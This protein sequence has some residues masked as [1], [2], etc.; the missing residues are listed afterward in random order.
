VTR[1][2]PS[3]TVTFLFTDIEGSTRLLDALGADAYADALAQHRRV[4]RLACSAQGGVQVDTQGDAFFFAF[5]SAPGALSAARAIATGLAHGP[6]RVRMGLHTGNPL[7]TEEGYVGSDVHLAA[8]IAASAHGG[9]IVVSSRTAALVGSTDAERQAIGL[10]DLGEHRLKDLPGAVVIFQL[11]GGVFPPLRTISNTNLPR[12]ASSFVGRDRELTGVLSLIRQGARLVSLTG[13]GGSGKTRLA[14]EAAATLVPEFKAGVFWIGLAAL[15][16]PSLVVET[17][18]RTL[19]AK[20]RLAEH[21]GER[22]LLLLL[23]NLEQVIPAAP[24]L[25]ALLTACPNLT[26]LVTSRE[27]L[28]VRGEVE[29]AVPPLAL[30]EAVSLFCERAQVDPSEEITEICR[31][32]DSLP[33][34]VELA[35]A[36]AKAISPAQILER[37]VD[38]LDMLKGG[39]DAD[40]RQQTLRATI[41]WSFGLLSEDERELFRRLSVFAGG[42]TLTEAEQVADADLD[43]MQALVEKSLVR[44]SRERYWMLETIREFAAERLAESSGSRLTKDRHAAW[45]AQFVERAEPELEASVQDSWLDRLEDEH[46]N[47]RSAV[48]WALEHADGN[49]ALRLAGSSATFWWVHGHWSE[50]RRWLE[51]ALAQPTAQDRALRAK[52]LEGAAHLAYRQLDYARAKDLAEEGLRIA[53]ELGDPSRIARLLRVL[54]LVSGVGDDNSLRVLTEESATFARE[55]GDIWALLMALS[56]LGYVAMTGGEAEPAAKLFQEALQLARGRGDRRSEAFLLEN[57]ALARFEQGKIADAR[58]HFLDSLHLAHRLGYVEVVGEDLMGI[59][60]VA[61]AAGRLEDAS[62][63]LGGARRLRAEIGSGLD[64]VEARVEARTVATIEPTLD[65]TKFADALDEGRR[66]SMDELVHLAEVTASAS[67]LPVRTPR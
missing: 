33:L 10:R 39:R 21:I 60:A 63:L 48:S 53:N 43:T 66:L 8:R 11:A 65:D 50:G 18:S 38:R 25:S 29:Y 14:L 36:R 47:V 19:G 27:L 57:L 20:I 7:V 44:L 32:L 41:D 56:N 28:R 9:Q 24:D 4:I 45:F 16:D 52:T 46:D 42:W 31:R 5:S 17:I 1:H 23:D 58:Q 54:G 64:E 26:L 13:P 61:T 37:L 62:R 30:P 49:L 12:P 67:H 15:R 35:A 3:G 59:A 34:A 51:A 40:P 22:E 6:I 2:L 55:A